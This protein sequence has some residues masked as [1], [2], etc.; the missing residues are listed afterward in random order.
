MDIKTEKAKLR[1][2]L[3]NRRAAL[4]PADAEARSL[5]IA[6]RL[7]AW[8]VFR[9]A[10]TVFCYFAVGREVGTAQVLERCRFAGKDLFIPAWDPVAGIYGPARYGDDVLV[11]GPLRI[12][13]PA[14]PEWVP[15]AGVDLVLM[16]GL[17][18]DRHGGRLG[19]GGGHYDRL[20]AS[21][22]QA[23][24]PA[25]PVRTGL[26]FSFQVLAD[27]P[28]EARDVAVHFVVTE[29]EIINTTRQGSP[30]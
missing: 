5:R 2:L 8:I 20:L 10:R 26:A 6:E 23:E 13:Q 9:K 28:F 22:A 14:R 12:P 30:D 3:R 25:G 16:P 18:F 4:D 15:L 29:E 21:V 17:A 19:Q 7:E 27:V 24:P 11:E 1:R